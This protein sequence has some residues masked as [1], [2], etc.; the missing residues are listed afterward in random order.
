MA[1]LLSSGIEFLLST[2]K[3]IG[4]KSF[5]Y[6]TFNATTASG[7]YP[8]SQG[9]SRFFRDNVALY[10]LVMN[11]D[12]DTI[13]LYGQ[14]VRLTVS[15]LT[16]NAGAGVDD[17]ADLGFGIRYYPIRRTVG[18]ATTLC[19]LDSQQDPGAWILPALKPNLSDDFSF[20]YSKGTYDSH[21]W[22]TEDNF[23]CGADFFCIGAGNDATREIHNRGGTGVWILKRDGMLTLTLECFTRFEQIDVP[24]SSNSWG[25]GE[26]NVNGPFRIVAHTTAIDY[27]TDKGEDP[28]EIILDT[29]NFDRKKNAVVTSG[30]I[31][32]KEAIVQT[33]DI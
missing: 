23:I 28:V 1:G 18:I 31:T 27:A 9:G 10:F 32:K 12:D 15:N 33:V 22:F 11:N 24:Y 2:L 29:S 5:E 26:P 21:F 17:N 20:P 13:Q 3:A 7:Y 8:P 16:G 19:V 30:A 25:V 14:D 6:Y 4:L